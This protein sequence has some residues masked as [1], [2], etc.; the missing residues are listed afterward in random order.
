MNAS[1]AQTQNLLQNLCCRHAVIGAPRAV[2]SG[3][4]AISRALHC[5]EAMQQRVRFGKIIIRSVK[6]GALCILQK[7][8][9]LLAICGKLEGT[10]LLQTLSFGHRHRYRVDLFFVLGFSFGVLKQPE[11]IRGASSRGAICKAFITTFLCVRERSSARDSSV[12][13]ASSD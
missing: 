8:L 11:R 9:S 3:E 5:S 13:I 1:Q 6:L 10:T 4:P 12:Y 7:V 2:A